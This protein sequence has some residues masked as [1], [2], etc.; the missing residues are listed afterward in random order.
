M[1]DVCIVGSGAGASGVA[2]TLVNAGYKVVILEKGSFYKE[3]DLTKDEIAFC[4]R[5]IVTPKLNEEFH[6]VD[7]TPTFESGWDFWNGNIVGGSSNFMSGFFHTLHPKDFRLKSEFGKINGANVEDWVI[8]YDD[9][10]PYYDLV[11]RVVG[12]SGENNYFE[13]TH[14]HPISKY[15]DKASRELEIDTIKTPRAII[16]KQKGERN[17][18]YYSNFCGSYGCLSGAKGSSRTSLLQPLLKKENLKV[19]TN[20]FVYELEEKE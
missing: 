19:I 20:A 4:R 6:V 17:P 18:C 12:V 15:I 10:K 2:Y 3:K 7:G 5:S 11:E 1:I 16:T 14:E 9:L 8:S 13:A